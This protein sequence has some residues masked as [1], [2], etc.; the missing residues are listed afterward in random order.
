VVGLYSAGSLVGFARVVSDGVQF[1][2][3]TDVYVEREHR[4]RGLGIELVREA[5]T[6]GPLA[7][8]PVWMLG[9]RDAHSLYEKFGFERPD[10]RWLVRQVRRS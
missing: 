6:G 7:A 5:V 2:W 4:G 1:A 9:T 10:A 8:L 3:L